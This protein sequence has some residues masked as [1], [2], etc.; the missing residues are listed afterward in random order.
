MAD[1]EV[2]KPMEDAPKTVVKSAVQFFFGTV[3]SRCSGFFREVALGAWLGAT[4]TLAAFFVAY[5]F[6]QLLRR[7]FGESSLLSSFSP[8]F[9]QLRVQEPEKARLFFR[10]LFTSMTAALGAIILLLEVALFSWWKWGRATP[11]T[12]EILFLTGVMLP[13]VLFVCLY[14]L[15]SAL[16]QSDRKY[17][18]PSIAPI[19]FNLIF[20]MILW[21][22]KDWE[23]QAAVTALA[24]GVTFAFFIQWVFVALSTTSFLKQ[25]RWQAVKLWTPELKKMVSAMGLTIIG[26]GA[27]QINS[28]VDTLFAR[29]ADLAGPAYLYYAIRIYQLPLALFGIAL[30]SALLPPLARARQEGDRKRFLTLLQFALRKSF[31]L[32]IPMTLALL[33]FGESIVNFVYGRGAFDLMATFQTTRCLWG[34]A[35][36]L[37][38]AVAV[39]IL[40]PAFYA[41]K[42]FRTPLKASLLSVAVNFGLNC[43]F[44]YGFHWGSASVATATS[45]AALMNAA[46]LFFSLS[47]QEGELIDR[48]TVITVGK[49]GLCALLSGFFT[50]LIGY[51]LIGGTAASL[52]MHNSVLS[53]P[54]DL[55]SQTLH[56]GIYGGT[57]VLSFLSYAWMMKVDEVFHMISLKKDKALSN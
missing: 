33:V 7:L 42:N 29:S 10:D 36:G 41:Q 15:F 28:F 20:L 9:E 21:S 55:F 52:L 6:S 16:L 22:V 44:I 56:L 25:M 45:I 11:E 30:S 1:I 47:K 53:F 8:H 19:F 2:Q 37:V 18:I 50:L 48:Q 17:F 4:P 51:F 31:S 12:Q 40:A 23:S 34:Y 35:I 57:F 32:M 26:I 46:Y 54:R 3:L 39:L 43:L 13:G 24:A 27:V 49:I 14:A 5:R 38:P